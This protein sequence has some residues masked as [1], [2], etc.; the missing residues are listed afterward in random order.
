MQRLVEESGRQLI[1]SACERG[2]SGLS[3]QLLAV[4]SEER[5][6]LQRPLEESGKRIA[7]MKTMIAE[8]ERSLRELG[9]LFM[10]EQQHL[11]DLFV[12]RH[13]AFLAGTLPLANQEFERAI[14]RLRGGPGPRYRRLEG[15]IRKLLHEVSRMAE[16]ALSNARKVREVGEAAVE[17]A[18]R[19]LEALEEQTALL[20]DVGRES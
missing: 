7:G 17:E 14:P 3:E 4:I 19:R 8:A 13:K 9:Y 18:R 20:D 12:D 15:E 2:L 16:Q 11:S 6:A 10:A 1:Y 5:E